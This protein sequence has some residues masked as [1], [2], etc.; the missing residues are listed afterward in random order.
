MVAPE[1]RQMSLAQYAHESPKQKAQHHE[2]EV[3][4]R[5]RKG[6]RCAPK[7]NCRVKDLE[8][9]FARQYGRLLPDDD[10]GRDCVYIMANHLAHRDAAEP[11]FRFWVR[12]WA[13]WYSAAEMADLLG[14]VL[15][16]PIKWDADTLGERIGLLD[17]VRTE[18]KA[19]TIGAVDCK[20][21]KRKTRRKKRAAVRG[22][23]RRLDAG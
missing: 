11:R 10:A 7:T 2:I 1:A 15:P 9:V 3:R 23:A 4:Y 20:K 22:R 8:R 12:R 17:A 6:N 16:D 13:P 21:A 5:S 14:Q 19:W 18:L